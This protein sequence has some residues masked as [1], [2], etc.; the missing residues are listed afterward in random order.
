VLVLHGFTGVPMSMRPLAEAF[1]D[2]GFGV[3][4]PRLPGHGTTPEDLAERGFEDW[5]ATAEAAYLELAAAHERVVAVGMSMGGTLACALATNH[6]ELAG[7]ILINPFIEPHPDSFVELL[8]QMLSSGA[9]SI[10]SIGSDINRPGVSGGGYGETP[11]APLLSLVEAVRALAPR[12][13]GI[14][15]PVLLFSSRVDHVVP[16]STGDYFESKVAGPLERVHLEHS[17]HVATLDQDAAELEARAVA[18][19]QKVTAS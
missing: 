14:T 12:L 15:C 1:A 19:A 17:F 16:T 7:L 5:Y 3:E 8:G 18:F 10:P 11:I 9:R 2:A 6:P 4:L 13:G